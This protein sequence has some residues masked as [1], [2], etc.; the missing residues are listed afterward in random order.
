M[1][2]IFYARKV[3][4]DIDSCVEKSAKRPKVCLLSSPVDLLVGQISEIYF[5]EIR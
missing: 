5:E 1:K 4:P 3:V 2:R